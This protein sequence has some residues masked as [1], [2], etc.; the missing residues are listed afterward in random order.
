MTLPTCHVTGFPVPTIT[1][2]KL[3]GQK[4]HSTVEGKGGTLTLTNVQRHH[5]GTYLCSATN[6]LATMMK[7]TQ[8]SV[9]VVPEFTVKPSTI[10]R[11]LQGERFVLNCSA[12]G[13]PAPSITWQRIGG[14]LPVGWSARSSETGGA[15]VVPSA[16]QTDAG[17]YKCVATSR[18]LK[19]ETEFRVKVRSRGEL[20]YF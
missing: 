1:W 5:S 8:L 4:P 14:A 16:Q 2:S 7:T 20:K 12:T 10:V 18:P 17:R 19:A 3:H 9:M 15:L 6:S 11:M 13:S